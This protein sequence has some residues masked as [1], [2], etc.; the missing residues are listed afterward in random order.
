[1]YHIC[2][3]INGYKN[4]SNKNCD[5]TS[6]FYSFFWHFAKKYKFYLFT[7]VFLFIFLS[8]TLNMLLVP[9]IL[10]YFINNISKLS[11]KNGIF[12]VF[13]CVFSSANFLIYS[14]G[15]RFNFKSMT[16]IMEDVR[17]FLFERLLKQ[18]ISYFNYKQSGEIINKVEWIVSNIRDIIQ[19]TL[20]FA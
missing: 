20:L 12:L 18:T 14:I 4:M 17:K 5:F 2:N 7:F 3:F 13:L 19:I 16:Y 6:N 8:Y 11:L 10:K 9:Y 15:A 1:M